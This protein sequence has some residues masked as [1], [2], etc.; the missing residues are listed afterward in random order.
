MQQIKIDDDIV[1][2]VFGKYY[3]NIDLTIYDKNSN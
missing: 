1:E 3:E 2:Q